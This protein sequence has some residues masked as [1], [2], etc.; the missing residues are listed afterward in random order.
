M[1]QFYHLTISLWLCLSAH[2]RTYILSAFVSFPGLHNETWT[3]DWSSAKVSPRIQRCPCEE[4]HYSQVQLH[5]GYCP[6]ARQAY[7]RVTAT[8]YGARS[9]SCVS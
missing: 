2:L 8:L 7:G 5:T 1:F 3:W 9:R 4:N 6:D